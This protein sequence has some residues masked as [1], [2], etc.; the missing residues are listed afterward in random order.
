M[1]IIYI[2]IH[3]YIYIYNSRVRVKTT[4]VP[5]Y[6]MFFQ[7][8]EALLFF[9]PSIHNVL[10]QLPIPFQIKELQIL[11]KVSFN[12]HSCLGNLMH[13]AAWGYIQSMG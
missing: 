11:C 9:V 2:Y 12:F 3:I 13:R 7:V 10:L 1:Y 6:I 5:N 8:Y 4:L